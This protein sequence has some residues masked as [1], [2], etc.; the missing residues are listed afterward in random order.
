MKK[1]K[2]IHIIAPVLLLWIAAIAVFFRYKTE[3]SWPDVWSPLSESAVLAAFLLI[4][5]YSLKTV[6]W[7]IPLNA[8][9]IGAGLLF[10]VGP[11]IAM[12]YLGLI[13]E[14]TLGFFLGRRL[15]TGQVRMILGKYKYSRWFLETVEKNGVMSCFLFRVLLG[16]PTDVTNMFFGTLNIRYTQFLFPSLLGLTPHMLPVVFLGKAVEHPL[17]REFFVPFCI[18]VSL[19]VC[20][21]AAYFLINKRR[22]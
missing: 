22:T 19:A 13:V 18:S 14:L 7:I 3:L 1:I 17:S 2:Y 15:G 16:P 4:G 9:Y 6:I 21:L 11:A 5:I 10:P 8:L 20:S 12:T